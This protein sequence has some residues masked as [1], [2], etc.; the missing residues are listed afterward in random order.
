MNTLVIDIETEKELREVGGKQNMHMLGVTVVGV[1][2][3]A[4]DSFYVYEKEEFPKL[5][6][7]MTNS[8]LAIGFNSKHF[9]F[10]V[11]QPHV[12]QDLDTLTHLDL[13]EE[14][15]KSLGFRV[16]LNNLCGAT[17]GTQKSGIGLEAID[18]WR[19]GLKDKVKN[20]C[21]QDVRLTR[22]LY[23]FG[24]KNGFVLADTRDRGRVRVMVNWKVTAPSLKKI[25]EDAFNKRLAVELE[26]TDK[27]KTKQKE[28]VDIQTLNRD[29]LEGY[30]H[31]RQKH[32]LFQLARVA[33][34]VV[35]D[36]SYQLQNDVQQSL[37]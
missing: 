29:T 34:V 27:D 30:C 9:D 5:E 18:W 20:Y 33:N 19:R 36:E 3:Y 7:L 6:E 28:T 37:I 22:D 14:V 23:E 2:N 11:L 31:G 13:M 15:E 12:E 24:K 32:A 35:T 1:Y 17:L 10:P 16:S 4:D 8:Q 21:I 25:L 26:Y